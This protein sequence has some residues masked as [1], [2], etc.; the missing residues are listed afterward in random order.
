MLEARPWFRRSRIGLR[1]ARQRQ[2]ARFSIGWGGWRDPTSIT[3]ELSV[4][5]LVRLCDN[6]R[7]GVNALTFSWVRRYCCGGVVFEQRVRKGEKGRPP[8]VDIDESL[9]RLDA[10]PENAFCET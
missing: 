9:H 8:K 6:R 5:G 10:R 2:R 4:P 1:G 7:V 3:G